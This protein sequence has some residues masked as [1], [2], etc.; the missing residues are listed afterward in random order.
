MDFFFRYSFLFFL[1]GIIGWVLELFFRR[2]VSQHKWVNPGFLTGPLLPLYGFGVVAFYLFSNEIPWQNLIAPGWLSYLVEILVIGVALTIIEY[3]AGLIFIKGTKIKLWDYSKRWGN[4]Q[5]IVCPLFSLIW[6]LIGAF[7]VLVLN[8]GFVGMTNYVMAEGHLI[9]FSLCEG[10]CYGILVI[11]FGYNI[12]IYAK[13]RK[14]IADKR[15]VVDWDKIKVSIQDHF[16]KLSK[17]A[18]WVF[19][20]AQK[21]ED[22]GAMMREYVAVLQLEN[23]KRL[24]EKARK[25]ALKEE[26]RQQKALQKEEEEKK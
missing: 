19:P 6:A 16:K 13:I 25:K 20:F 17:H 14:A 10:L 7:Y 12:G 22:F 3:L 8:P 15:L 23:K 2:F 21:M 9:W 4:I 24:D 1:G 18:N 11:D 26:K 5:G